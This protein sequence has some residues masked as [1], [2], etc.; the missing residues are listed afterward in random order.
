MTAAS[1]DRG[2]AVNRGVVWVLLLAFSITVY[3]LLALAF[4][5]VYR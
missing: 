4:R 2:R 1:T 5:A 3:T